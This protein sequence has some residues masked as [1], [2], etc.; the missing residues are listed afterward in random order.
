MQK[1][2]TELLGNAESRERLGKAITEGTLPHAFLIGGPEGSGK[3]T[4]AK[5]ICAASNCKG[6]EAI[7]CMRCNSCR[8]IME[9]SFIDLKFFA[10]RRTGLLSALTICDFLR[11]TLCSPVRSPKRNFTLLRMH[12]A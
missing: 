6:G 10:S 9:E 1:Y 3:K 12:I 5:L 7:P 8:R 4:F 11:K 2:F